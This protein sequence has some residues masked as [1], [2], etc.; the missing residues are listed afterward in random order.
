M[1]LVNV[2]CT[3]LSAVTFVVVCL[4]LWKS[5]GAS[6]TVTP[7]RKR[8]EYVVS[9]QA[10]VPPELREALCALAHAHRVV[11]IDT[12]TR[13]LRQPRAPSPCRSRND[14]HARGPRSG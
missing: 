9:P 2:V 8:E 4:A 7:R 10:T 5:R 14:A 3:S 11:H 1:H 6:P 13:L 12:L